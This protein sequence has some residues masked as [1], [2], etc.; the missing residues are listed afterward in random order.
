VGAIV[1]NDH[2]RQRRVRRTA[3]W[4]ALVALVVYIGFIAMSVMR[5]S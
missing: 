2:D 5:G 1:L 4:L 3:L